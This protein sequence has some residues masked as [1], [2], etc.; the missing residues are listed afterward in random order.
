MRFTKHG[1]YTFDKVIFNVAFFLLLI[2]FM[3]ELAFFYD[4][5][6]FIGKNYAHCPDENSI[7]YCDIEIE[8]QTIRLERG[9]YWNKPNIFFFYD[10]EIMFLVLTLA[11]VVND[12]IHNK[13]II[14]KWLKSLE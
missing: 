2:L 10:R 3:L 6:P 13:G 4:W 8:G 1:K 7:P 14:K 9:E 5:N 11:F 12:R